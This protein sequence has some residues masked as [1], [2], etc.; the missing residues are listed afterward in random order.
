MNLIL[1]SWLAVY[2]PTAM[3]KALAMRAPHNRRILGQEEAHAS[4]ISHHH[5][6]HYG[7]C[8]RWRHP[9]DWDNM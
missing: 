8:R 4:I 3:R 9:V 1:N 6:H 2:E 5:H 7:W